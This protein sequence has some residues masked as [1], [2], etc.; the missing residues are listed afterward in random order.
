[1]QPVQPAN[2]NIN[3]PV[4]LVIDREEELVD[5][6]V[7]VLKSY[8]LAVFGAT[9]VPEAIRLFD[10]IHPNLVVIEPS[11]EG[12]IALLN[13]IRWRQ[14]PTHIVVMT[15]SEKI[16]QTVQGLG[17]DSIV[18]KSGGPQSLIDGILYFLGERLMGIPQSSGIHVLVVDDE[19]EILDILSDFLG[20]RGYTVFTARNGREALEIAEREPEIALVL[21]DVIIPEIGGVEALKELMKRNPHPSVIMMSA[22]H[23]R[24]I[25]NQ[26]LNLGAFDYI[27]KPFELDNLE[28]TIVACLAHSDFKRRQWWKRLA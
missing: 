17:I 9:T 10:L 14:Q 7:R 15:E 1:M 4:V 28:T 12:G 11:M 20:R 22:I 18:V 2:R 19:E 23:D 5:L 21:L 16:I 13:E 27:I 25:A 3:T 26:A 24:E 6:L 8:H